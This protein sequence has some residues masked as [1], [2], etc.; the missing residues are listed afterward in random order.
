MLSVYRKELKTFFSTYTGYIFISF[1]LLT[2][3]IYSWFVNYLNQSPE[4]EYVLLNLNFIY[5]IAVPLITMKTFAE[6]RR[7]KTDILLYSL[8]LKSREIVS[9]KY[10]AQLTLLL[11]PTAIICVYPIILT[12][13]GTVSLLT[14]YS[15]IVGFFLMGAALIAIGNFISSVTESQT[16]CAIA[17]FSALFVLYLSRT[18]ANGISTSALSSL[19]AVCIITVA[20]CA[21]AAHITKSS[22]TGIISGIFLLSGAVTVY[23]YYPKLYEGLL[24][25]FLSF[26]SMFDRLSYFVT[27]VFDLTSVVYY[28]S[29]A[30][31]FSFLTVCTVEKRRWN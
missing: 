26:I 17:T 2:T 15:A 8:P 7:Q 12:L 30:W 5:L 23:L 21:S 20:V 1:I 14:C 9:G 25:K 31:L 22:L 10:A 4:F 24:Q 27:G 11:I 28:L 6:E 13:F 29:S 16:V 19:I 3:G 18:L